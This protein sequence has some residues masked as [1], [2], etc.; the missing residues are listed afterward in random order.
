M[1]VK[2]LKGLLYPPPLLLFLLTPVSIAF[3]VLSMVYLGSESP[4]A[5]V[6]YV[7]AAYLLTAICFR[8]PRIVRVAKT[9]GEK[10][11]LLRRL[12]E[13]DRFR[14]NVSLYGA[15]LGNTAYAAFHLGLGIYHRTFWFFSLAGYYLFLALMRLFLWRH[16]RKYA[17]RERMREELLRY[18][19]CGWAFLWMNLTL[20]LIVFFMI[21][22]NR[23]FLHHEITT[24]TMAAYT[25]TAFV[26][27]VINIVKYR[28]YQSPVF[29][30]TRAIG[31]ASASVSMLTLEA[32]MLTTFGAEMLPKTR[33]L[34]LALSG[35]AVAIF[36][37]VEA[38]YMIVSSTKK[39]KLLTEKSKTNGQQ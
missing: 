16:S 14:V 25:F 30:A 18:R 33:R 28:K 36:V 15:L 20:S 11:K 29:S 24:I 12:R 19:A 21:Y 37:V 9:L 26:F 23:T 10:S 38:I 13:D 34:F 32:T 35:G 17:P 3:L 31:L 22:W 39:L 2:K 1:N 4:I 27:A 8:I 5:I 6:S 7:L